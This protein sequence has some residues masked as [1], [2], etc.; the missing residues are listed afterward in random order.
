MKRSPDAL[1]APME[2]AESLSDR[3]TGFSAGSARADVGSSARLALVSASIAQ[4][5]ASRVPPAPNFVISIDGEPRTASPL[6]TVTT[7]TGDWPIYFLGDVNPTNRPD[8]DAV[9]EP[10]K[11]YLFTYTD[12]PDWWSV[13]LSSYGQ[14]RPHER[15]YPKNIFQEATYNVAVGSEQSTVRVAPGSFKC[16]DIGDPVEPSMA[17]LREAIGAGRVVPYHSEAFSIVGMDEPRFKSRELSREY[18]P[19]RLYDAKAVYDKLFGNVSASAGEAPSSRGFLSETDAAMIMAVVEDRR[20]LWQQSSEEAGVQ[21]RYALGL[22]YLLIQSRN[23][24]ALR[25]P[26]KPL[27][28]DRAYRIAGRE[29][30]VDQ[31]GGPRWKV[32]ANYP[33][34][35]GRRPTVGKEINH[36]RDLAHMFNHGYSWWLATGDPRAALLFQAQAAYALAAHYPTKVNGYTGI[37]SGNVQERA[38]L[39]H[40]SAMW[41]LKDVVD[42]LET[43]GVGLFWADD[44]AN[45]MISESIEGHFAWLDDTGRLNTGA[46]QSVEIGRVVDRGSYSNFMMQ[47]YGPEVAYLWA[48]A[49]RPE[50]LERLAEHFV[51]RL[52]KAGGF[53]GLDPG[54]SDSAVPWR[55]GKDKKAPVPYRDADGLAAFWTGPANIENKP[56]DRFDRAPVHYAVRAYWLLKMAEDAVAKGW[57]DPVPELSPTIVKVEGDM[58]RTR[59]WRSQRNLMLKHAAVPFGTAD[60]PTLSAG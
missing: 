40:F 58:R 23:H 36:G 49:G 45:E 21:A 54:K 8:G 51:I 42:N 19:A 34:F 32:P 13:C 41:R 60:A 7:P 12:R 27:P 48:S 44:R 25:D 4:D 15:G 30:G 53:A 3:V 57:M 38:T 24:H 31:Y 56:T 46:A 28:G 14:D 16:F 52:G 2:I 33:D 29:K 6:E 26:Q 22:P 9:I 11:A 35:D 20:R 47:A 10:G 1:S 55:L 50:L 39:N 18:D 17:R 37:R 5:A 43:T 59:S